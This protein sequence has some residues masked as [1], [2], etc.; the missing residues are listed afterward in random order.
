MF[1]INFSGINDGRLAWT[2]GR[3]SEKIIIRDENHSF[4]KQKE[5]KVNMY[6]HNIFVQIQHMKI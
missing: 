1:T 5:M 4:T 6:T 3:L 2:S